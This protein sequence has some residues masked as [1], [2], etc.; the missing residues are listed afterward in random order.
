MRNA[1]SRSDAVAAK[2]IEAQPSS[3]QISQREAMWL[4]RPNSIRRKRG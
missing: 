3:G 4:A 1:E 2:A